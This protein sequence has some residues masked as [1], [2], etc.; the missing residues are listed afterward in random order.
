M[1]RLGGEY[2]KLTFSLNKYVF[3]WQIFNDPVHGSIELHPLLVSIVNTPAF[4]RL[5]NIKQLGIRI[6]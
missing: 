4:N 5:K 2:I 6:L 3:I 1:H